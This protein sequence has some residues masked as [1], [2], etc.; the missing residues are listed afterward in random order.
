[1]CYQSKKGVT[2]VIA[3]MEGGGA[4]KVVSLLI[5][6]WMELGVSVNLITFKSEEHDHFKINSAVK[7]INLDL[8]KESRSIF[9]AFF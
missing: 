9:G 4:Q 6:N 2:I 8:I 3:D 5:N 7:R 1:M